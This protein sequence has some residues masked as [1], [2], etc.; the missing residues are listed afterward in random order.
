MDFCNQPH[1]Q[2]HL[3]ISDFLD[4]YFRLRRAKNMFSISK[5]ME[6]S[7]NSDF[8]PLKGLTQTPAESSGCV[9]STS[10]NTMKQVFSLFLHTCYIA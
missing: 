5:T 9:K 8:V 1:S 4:I 2:T 3:L 6:Q 7:L 10:Q